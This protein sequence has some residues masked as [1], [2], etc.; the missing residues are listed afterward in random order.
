MAYFYLDDAPAQASWLNDDERNVLRR[1][2]E[3]DRSAN[4]KGTQ[5]SFMAVLRDPM[6]YVLAAMNFCV[7]CGTNAVSFWT[8]TL[9]KGVGMT[10]F[11]GIGW[12]TGLISA[13]SAIAMIAIG[14]HSDRMLER[15]WHFAACGILGAPPDS[16]HCRWAQIVSR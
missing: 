14:R 7:N 10:G 2:F 1:D 9:L 4:P 3:L 11:S 15:R 6:I 16:S 12:L 13:I 5:H 8:P